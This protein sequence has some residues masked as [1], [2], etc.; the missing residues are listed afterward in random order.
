LKMFESGGGALSQQ[1]TPRNG[2]S[3]LLE[4]GGGRP[5]LSARALGVRHLAAKNARIKSEQDKQL[6]TNR[7]KRLHTEQEKATRRI[8]E[9][10]KRSSQIKDL[11][12]RNAQQAQTQ[13]EA[14]MYLQ[15][16]RGLQRQALTK[17]RT[18]REKNVADARASVW[19]SRAA[20]SVEMKQGRVQS[21]S[22]VRRQRLELEAN[23]VQKREQ[24]RKAEADAAA[25][26]LRDRELQMRELTTR[27]DA[28]RAELQ[29]RRTRH[30]QLLAEME[31]EEMR[32]INSLTECQDDQRDAFVRL[33]LLIRE[34]VPAASRGGTGGS[35]ISDAAARSPLRGTGVPQLEL[36]KG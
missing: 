2:S 26:R 6:L 9:T 18:E 11:R 29:M 28:K 22:E 27:E 21:E 3:A 13:Q 7:I 34:G 25:R 1:S 33:E 15:M 14:H 35:V 23:A 32:L 12:E 4:P 19:R 24:I 10:R 17:V 8:D 20:E 31:A 30:A 16:E 5:D 36:L